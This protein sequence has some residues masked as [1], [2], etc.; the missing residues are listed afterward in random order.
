MLDDEALQRMADRLVGIE[1]VVGVTLGGSRARG[2]HAPDSD[3]DLGVYVEGDADDLVLDALAS[4]ASDEPASWGGAGGW[5]PWV[6]GGAWLVVG[7]TRVDWIRRELERVDAQWE[8]A[9]AGEHALHA[10]AG[11]PLGFLDVA[12]CGELALARI[13]AD[14][15]GAL[16]ERQRR[17]RPMPE[18]LGDALEARLWEARFEASAAAKGA[19]RGD[20]AFVALALGRALTLAALAIHGRARAWSTNEKG[21]VAAADGLPGAPAGFA[22]RVAEA[23]ALGDASPASL[24]AAVGRTEALLAEVEA[25]CGGVSR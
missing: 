18:A 2:A 8:R 4:T 22:A 3:V 20:A 16:A 23:L 15:S 17:M 6:D 21:L 25:T 11:H 14:P 13:L 10:Q 1:G 12:Y 9:L 5:G 7:G 19:A 24:V